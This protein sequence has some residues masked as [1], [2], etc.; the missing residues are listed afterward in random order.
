MSSLDALT[1]PKWGLTMTEG[2]LVEWTIDEGT[3]FEVGQEIAEIETSKTVNILEAAVSGRLQRKIAQPGDTL[4]VGAL[5]GV[6]ADGNVSA[7]AVEAFIENFS[8]S[9]PM[10]SPQKEPEITSESE[11]VSRGAVNATPMAG[12]LARQL[13]V[14][15]SE[16]AATGARGRITEHDV[17]RAHELRAGGTPAQE[18]SPSADASVESTPYDKIPFTSLRKKIGI[19]LQESKRQAPHFRLKVVV[20]VDSMLARLKQINA[21]SSRSDVTVNDFLIKASG[22]ALVRN[23]NCNVQVFDD[24]LLRF[25]H[26]D[27]SVAVALEDGVIAPIVRAADTK[28]IND[29]AAE[30]KKLIEK[31]HTG[32]L[33]TSDYV[34]GTF[35]V[36]N[37]GM[38]GVE[39]FDAII[40][41]PQGAI[42]ATGAVRQA[43][44]V[45]NGVSTIASTMTLTLACDHRVI[46]GVSAAGLLRTLGEILEEPE[47]IA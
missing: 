1:M 43:V 5:I 29:I 17:R 35:T 31:A 10:A 32:K 14:P 46:D 44:I 18:P 47:V 20:P 25:K 42:L 39:E 40:N 38:Y 45:K 21:Q 19:R 30:T 27:V 8:S 16:C 15:L 2:T 11:R 41:P 4:P 36:S 13:G 34:G 33:E 37:L 12:R 24:S 6:I 3:A 9:D 23:L 22:T 28:S 26:A 7:S